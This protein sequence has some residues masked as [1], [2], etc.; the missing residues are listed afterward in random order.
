MDKFVFTCPNFFFT[1]T[2]SGACDKYEICVHS[3]QSFI[4]VFNLVTTIVLV[5]VAL[6]LVHSR[7]SVTPFL[8]RL[9]SAGVQTRKAY[10]CFSIKSGLLKPLVSSLE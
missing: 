9:V 10:K 4:I 2:V 6:A 1:G 8:R 7:Q 3:R 5:A